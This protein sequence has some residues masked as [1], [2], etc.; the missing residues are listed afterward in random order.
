MAARNTK[1]PWLGLASAMILAGS[2][3]LL[4]NQAD[5]QAVQPSMAQAQHN[6][7]QN[8]AAGTTGKGDALPE[9]SLPDLED[10]THNLNEWRGKV[11]L[12]NFWASWCPPC[13]YET[14]DLIRYQRQ[15]G[16][17]G[18]Q[19]IGVGLDV[20]RKLK[21][22]RRTFGMNYPVLVGGER[23]A[24]RLLTQWGDTKGIL[25]YTVVIAPDGK[26]VYQRPGIFDD[27]TFAEV[28]DPLLEKSK[29]AGK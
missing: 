3:L 7:P 21:N 5:G 11:I 25:P 2:A 10:K 23:L 24:A 20:P 12:L 26:I 19:V 4:T 1:G 6:A 9:L 13:Q 28:I 22:F 15:Y 29:I 27:D 17:A 18:L 8:H 16:A 14:P